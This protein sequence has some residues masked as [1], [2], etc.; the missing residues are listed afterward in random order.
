[1]EAGNFHICFSFQGEF[2]CKPRKFTFASFDRMYK[3]AQQSLL[4]PFKI[5]FIFF[6]KGLMLLDS[7]EREVWTIQLRIHSLFGF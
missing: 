4:I 7:A 2:L 1:M 3:G 5:I 6:W